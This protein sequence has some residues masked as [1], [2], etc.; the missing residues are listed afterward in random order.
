MNITKSNLSEALEFPA[1]LIGRA[2]FAAILGTVKLES[3]QGTLSV[4][5][6]SIDQFCSTTTDCILKDLEP[7]CVS[8]SNL[9]NLLPL[10]SDSVE[11]NLV[12]NKLVISGGGDFVLN[13]MPAS[14]FPVWKDKQSKAIGVNCKDLAECIE[15]VVFAAHTDSSRYLLYGVH[16]HTEAKKVIA[17]ASNGRELACMEKALIASDSDF[18]IPLPFVANVCKALREKEAVVSV[19]DSKLSI[20]HAKG[21]YCC[22]LSEGVYLSTEAIIS[23]ERDLL[24][25]I[26]PEKWIPCFRIPSFIRDEKL[27]CDIIVNNSS[28][29]YSGKQG[30]ISVTTPDKLKEC[31]L[32]L[33]GVSFLPCLEALEGKTKL[34]TSS[35]K[36]A[37]VLE[38]GDLTIIAM[39]LLS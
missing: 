13:T 32:K 30:N 24:G 15:S 18:I 12:D 31:K 9:Q 38:C 25:T 8:A 11:M 29:S 26:V 7:C 5:S 28:I 16:V 34:S 10:F 3:K 21:K 20:T 1:S 37:V 36:N 19:S 14:E 39:Q 27:R 17:E 2:P 4:S 22:K 35:A 33:N 23:S 6:S